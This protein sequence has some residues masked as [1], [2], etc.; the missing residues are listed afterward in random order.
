MAFNFD[1]GSIS[2]LR[3]IAFASARPQMGYPSLVV[4]QHNGEKYRD[5]VMALKQS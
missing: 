3:F 2:E 5:P 4:I 1:H